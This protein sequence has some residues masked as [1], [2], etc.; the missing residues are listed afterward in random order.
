MNDIASN[1]KAFFD[2][3]ILEKIEAGIALLGSEIKSVRAGQVSLQD[4][5]GV[6]RGTEIF[7][8]NAYIAPYEKG[9]KEGYE[10][11]RSRRLLLH[12]KEIDRLIGKIKEKGLAL[13]PLR[14]YFS[15]NV[16]KVELGLGR[17]KKKYEKRES[18]KKRESERKLRH[19]R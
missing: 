6:I 3:E 15:H 8:L 2:Y 4:A 19:L 10:P 16:L 11:Y 12:K 18:I 17:G 7:L 13:I 9:Q 14:F 1:K 5:H